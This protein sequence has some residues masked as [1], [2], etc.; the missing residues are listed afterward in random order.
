MKE[1]KNAELMRRV[2]ANEPA[3]LY[4]YAESIRDSNPIEA[5]KYTL[6][7]AQLGLPLA[8]ESMG[9]YCLAEGDADGASHYY[10]SGAKAGLMSCTVKR[11][12]LN[13]K[14]NNNERLALLELEELAMMG[15]QS[16]CMALSDYYLTQGNERESEYWRNKLTK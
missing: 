14:L 1:P 7:A 16:A 2:D 5:R 3:A 15:V 11:A 9:D 13:I 12:M 8:M 10:R 4:E 6:F